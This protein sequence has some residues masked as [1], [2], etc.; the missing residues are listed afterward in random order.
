[1]TLA[2]DHALVSRVFIE[3]AQTEL[4][5]G[6]LLQASEKAWGATARALKA[7]AEPRGW[8][9]NSHYH[10]YQIVRRLIDLTGNEELRIGFQIAESLHA[11]FYNG[12]M[13]ETEVRASIAD[14]RQLVADLHQLITDADL[15]E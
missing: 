4:D 10:Y 15:Q 14:V 1:M 8:Q 9:H 3:Q 5:S 7:I 13:P 6:D 12:W 2:T 11:N